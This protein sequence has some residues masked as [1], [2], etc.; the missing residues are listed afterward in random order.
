MLY[1]KY[2]QDKYKLETYNAIEAKNH[3]LIQNHSFDVATIIILYHSM[4]A[5]KEII[6]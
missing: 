4:M 6:G 3:I 5:R 2:G 1:D